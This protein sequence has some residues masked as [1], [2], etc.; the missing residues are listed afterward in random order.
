MN[1]VSTNELKPLNEHATNKY[2]SQRDR[3]FE[4]IDDLLPTKFKYIER[5]IQHCSSL[6]FIQQPTENLDFNLGFEALRRQYE[7]TQLPDWFQLI[8]KDF[9]PEEPLTTKLSRKI[10]QVLVKAVPPT[11]LRYQIA[12][13][14]LE[15]GRNLA[16]LI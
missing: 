13:L 8:Q 5:Y 1:L 10:Q 14:D 3:Q 15:T 16:S 11:G 7:F 4:V 12:Q 2:K 6:K 9:K